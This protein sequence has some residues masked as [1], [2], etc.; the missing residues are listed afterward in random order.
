[1][2]KKLLAT[3]IIGTRPEAIKLAPVIKTFNNSKFF[4]SRVVL[5][6]QHREMVNEVLEIFEIKAN[7]N[8]NIMIESQTL[9]YLVSNIIKKL[10][11]ELIE[12]KPDLLI[13]Q[14]DTSSA[15]AGALTAFQLGIPIAHVEAGLRTGDLNEPFPEEANRRL[16]SQLS[17]LH[18]A[19]T[20]KSAENLKKADITQGVFITGNTVI[21]ALKEESRKNFLPDFLKNRDLKN[22]KFILATFHRRENWGENINN[23]CNSI[24]EILNLTKNVFFIIPMHKNKIVRNSIL[25]ILSGNPR[26]ILTEPLKYNELIATM[27]I[28]YFIITDSG[29]IQEEAPTLGKPVLVLRN[30]TEREETI[31]LGASKLVG[32]EKIKIIKESI[33]LISDKLHYEK[34]SNIKNP[35]G[36]GQ[37]SKLILKICNTY[38]K[39]H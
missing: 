21:D 7:N 25:N 26:I 33:K 36:D 18:F 22:K 5:T 30:K 16:I 11:E 39:G 9:N 29:G 1:M 10:N 27:K 28:C 32:T 31:H 19:P 24:L 14:G 37:A 15:F 23:I 6:G 3:F 8:F 13:I 34:M 4:Y 2:K 38:F 20:N 12:F 17:T 35:F